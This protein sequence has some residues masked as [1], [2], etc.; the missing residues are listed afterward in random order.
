MATETTEAPVVETLAFQAET[1]QLLDLMIHSLYSNKEIFLRE[2]ISNSSDALDRLRFEALTKPELMEGDEKLEIR[3]EADRQNRTLTIH[4]NGIGMSR[5]EVI[6]NIGTI[7][8]SGTR[9][10][11][12]RL[13]EG[14]SKQTIAELIG[15]FGVGFYSSFMAAERVELVTRRAGETAATRWESTG[16]GTYKIQ[17]AEK[18]GRG[19][20][21]KLHLK[22]EDR[23]NGMD[24]FSDRWVIS[25]IVRRYSDFVS[26]P[27]KLTAEKDPEIEDLAKEKETGEKPKMPLEEKTLNSMKPIWTMPQAEVTKEQYN[28]FYRHVSNDWTEPLKVISYKAEGRVEYQALLFVPAQAPYDLYYVASKPGLQ[29]YVKRIQ[30]MEKCEDLLP[31]YLRFVRG[32]VDS[33]DLALNVSREMLQQDRFITLMKKGLTK[34]LL[35]VFTEMKEKEY[36]TY[37]KFWKEFGRAIKEGVSAD[38]ENKEKLLEL[39]VF[40]SSNDPEKL[41]SL[42]DYVSRMKEDQKEIFYLPGESRA[43][44]ETSPHLEAIR[45]KGYEVLYLVDTVDELLTQS[46]NEYDGKKLKSVGKGTVNL[47]NEEEKKQ[48]EEE[49]KVKE[50]EMKPLLESLQKK[51]DEWVKQVRLTN[52]L[53][54]SPVCLVGAEHDYSPQLEKLLQK[55]KGGGPKQRRI[56]EL[57]PKHEMVAKLKQR[58][59]ANQNDPIFEEYA[60][61]LFGAGLLAEGGELPEPVK[62][63]RA[64]AELMTRAI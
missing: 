39:L 38:Y 53:T 45:D 11:V 31:H 1:K 32:V 20:T 9:E 25:R 44:V 4:D 54:N 57:N 3:L 50:E 5:D 51:L 49:L 6:N 14:E 37:L 36:D 61:L 30:I 13:K 27:I 47:G 60:Q 62:F 59:D 21:I 42:K 40:E 8:K 55:G 41:T 22:P 58:F 35:D 7:A 18:P 2:L 23:E 63:N 56:M 29:L 52:R 12:N 33:P 46:L 19:T 43:Q 48:T 64:V 15:Q 10:L 17:D 24:E 28:D 34:K 16:D 26:Y